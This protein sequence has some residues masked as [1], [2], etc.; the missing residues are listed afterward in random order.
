MNFTFKN[1][2]IFAV[3]FKN[4]GFNQELLRKQLTLKNLFIYL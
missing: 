3:L 1:I 4:I 2:S